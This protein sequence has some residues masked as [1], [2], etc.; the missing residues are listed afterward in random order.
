M[1]VLLRP[2]ET[3]KDIECPVCKQTFRVYWERTSDGE[4]ETMRA[5][6]L[7]ELK[8]QHADDQTAAAHPQGLFNLPQWGGQPEFSG[9]ALL[10]GLSA[11]RPAF[12][13]TPRRQR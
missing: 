5:I 3:R 1:Q 8:L 4:R 7:G 6:V 9:A 10:G 2:S 13:A 11:V 12:S